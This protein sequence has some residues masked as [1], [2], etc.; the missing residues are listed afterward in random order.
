MYNI[1]QEIASAKA[2]Q[3]VFGSRSVTCVQ[4]RREEDGTLTTVTRVTYVAGKVTR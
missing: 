2:Q 3:K 1:A 4:E